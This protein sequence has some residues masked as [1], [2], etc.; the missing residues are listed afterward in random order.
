MKKEFVNPTVAL[1]ATIAELRKEI[2]SLKRKLK[3]LNKNTERMIE[4]SV[5]QR[6]DYRERFRVI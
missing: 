4:L 1:K 3:Y 5:K 6:L 2:K